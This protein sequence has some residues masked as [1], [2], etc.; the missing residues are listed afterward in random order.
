[1]THKKIPCF[2]DLL[3]R[4]EEVKPSTSN[5]TSIQLFAN[6]K[7]G[8]LRSTTTQKVVVKISPP[9][10]AN[11]NALEVE[12]G[13]YIYIHKQIAR[14]TPHILEGLLEGTCESDD[15][16]KEWK[17][18]DDPR[19]QSLYKEY[20]AM[21]IA[22]EWP[23]VSTARKK[24]IQK[25]FAKCNIPMTAHNLAM[26]AKLTLEPKPIR[27]VITPRLFDVPLGDFLI[28]EEWARTR[29]TLTVTDIYSIML[30]MAQ[31][32]Y[33]L[34]QKKIM[35]N[36]LHTNNI[37]IK[38]GAHYRAI[39]YMVPTKCALL[40]RAF[41]CFYDFDHGTGP[42]F[43]NT[44][45][46]NDFCESLGECNEFTANWDWY[47]FLSSLDE[48]LS[49]EDNN[50]PV[51]PILKKLIQKANPETDAFMGR[52]CECVKRDKKDPKQCLHCNVKRDF[53]ANMMSP[54]AF[55]LFYLEKAKTHGQINDQDL[56][57]F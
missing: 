47:T 53:L 4:W 25:A 11:D 43:H 30:Q 36:D 42:E 27:Y 46:D 21:R 16:V 10:D 44:T 40:A 5:S 49:Y 34:G 39:P 19:K 22:K 35:H 57:L 15:V 29:A 45:L 9:S 1:M 28:D 55:F 52:P 2:L 24:Q 32:L 20:F 50:V 6:L 37:F 17:H 54:E 38:V 18:D 33:V 12:R 41:V 8:K 31:G 3:E 26:R 13:I 56:F 23:L 14:D 51:P 48:I 7:P